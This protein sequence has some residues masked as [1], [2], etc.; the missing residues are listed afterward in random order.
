[1]PPRLRCHLHLNRDKIET[2]LAEL[3]LRSEAS[4]FE[5]RKEF[6]DLSCV[7]VT[8]SRPR[9]HIEEPQLPCQEGE[10]TRQLP[11]SWPRLQRAKA[12]RK[13]GLHRAELHVTQELGEILP[14]LRS[15]CG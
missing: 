8:K 7:H 1:M 9:Y 13:L 4:R 5:R 6:D 14:I 15:E 3:Y 2:R 11:Q 10:E 12:Q